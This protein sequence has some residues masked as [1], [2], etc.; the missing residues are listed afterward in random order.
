M[1]RDPTAVFR[2]IWENKVALGIERNAFTRVTSVRPVVRV[3][4]DQSILRETVVEYI[5][6]LNVY[7]SEL[8]TLGIKKPEGMPG[9]RLISLYGGGT[10][11][12]SEYG[13]LKF[14]IGRSEERRVGKECVSTCRSRWSPYH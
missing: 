1:Q 3:S 13:L 2:F 4:N 9:N 12:F 8:A 7:S 10:L 6:R 5:Q 11:I 14:H